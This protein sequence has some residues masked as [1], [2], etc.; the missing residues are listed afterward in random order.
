MEEKKTYEQALAELE[1]LVV[2]IEHPSTSLELVNKD[3]KKAVEL[4]E[5]C[6]NLL[7]E[8]EQKINKYC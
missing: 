7:R 5:Y 8:D 4:I 1:K 2:E 3:V 6:R